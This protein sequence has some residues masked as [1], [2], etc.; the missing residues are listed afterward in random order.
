MRSESNR[1]PLQVYLDSSD[2]SCLSSQTTIAPEYAEVERFLV[3]LQQENRIEL[4]FSQA[5][6]AEVSPVR[7]A[8]LN[9]AA[10]RL[11]CI[12]RLCGAKCLMPPSAL[13]E[14]EVRTATASSPSRYD[15]YRND[16]DWTPFQEDDFD[17]PSPGEMIRDQLKKQVTAHADRQRIERQLFD[18]KGRMKPAAYALLNHSNDAAL[19]EFSSKFPLSPAATQTLLLYL[20]G[21]GTRKAAFAE[22]QASFADLDVFAQWYEKNWDATFETSSWLRNIGNELRNSFEATSIEISRSY[23][24]AISNG[25]L[26]QDFWEMGRSMFQTLLSGMLHKIAKQIAEEV[27]LEISPENSLQLNEKMPGLFA[28][29]TIGLHIARR[30]AMVPG[31]RRKA[32][33]SDFGDIYH[34]LYLPYVDIFRCDAFVGSV[35]FEAKLPFSTRVVDRFADLPLAIEERLTNMQNG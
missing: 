27:D 13:L 21:I 34:S 15:V 19:S 14:A 7:Q 1:T 11:S 32:R 10:R 18:K 28:A 8:D 20:R 30:V 26:P 24:T 33:S 4:R 31:M 5:H 3:R 17:F 29:S 9:L 6:V 35:V 22:I 23:D 25:C 12:K 2:F 16:G